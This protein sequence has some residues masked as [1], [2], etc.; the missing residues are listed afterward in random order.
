MLFVQN[1]VCLYMVNRAVK[2][3]VKHNAHWY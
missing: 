2:R 1:T 3:A